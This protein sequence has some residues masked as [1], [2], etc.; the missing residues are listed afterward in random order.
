MNAN[1]LPV[2]IWVYGFPRVSETFIRDQICSLI[3]AGCDVTIY[4]HKILKEELPALSGFE[5]YKLLD[6]VVTLRTIKKAWSNKYLAFLKTFFYLLRQPR[7]STIT[8]IKQVVKKQDLFVS[9]LILSAYCI[10]EGFEIIHAHFGPYGMEATAL[11]KIGLTVKVVTT[12]HGYDLRLGLEHPEYY[13]EFID[14]ADRVVAI[15]TFNHKSLEQIGFTKNQIVAI[16]NGMNTRFYSPEPSRKQ[17]PFKIITVARLVQ[18]KALH[19][20]INSI[21]QVVTAR[22][23]IKICHEIIGEGPLREEL[24]ALILSLNAGN[25]IK[26]LGAQTSLEVKEHLA[27]SHLFV[28]SSVQEAFP[29]V[30]LE[31]QSMGL[32]VVSTNVGGI[33]ELLIQG[34]LVESGDVTSMTQGILSYIDDQERL[35]YAGVK[36]RN[37]II[38]NFDSKIVSQ[39]LIALYHGL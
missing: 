7:F 35:E 17:L 38:Q 3:D 36:N 13:K 18:E 29:T 27:S 24:E 2:L 14:H 21:H 9:Q 31:A 6:Q 25:Y 32:A 20:A 15:S 33:A 4:C 26:L 16:P 1:K 34:I 22:P 23:D 39:K 28:L 12:F 19:V 30:L 37:H 11:K 5:S 8:Y 10:Q